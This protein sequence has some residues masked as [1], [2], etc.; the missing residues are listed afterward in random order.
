MPE[1]IKWNWRFGQISDEE[2]FFNLRLFTLKF[3][4]ENNI[5]SLQGW[6]ALVEISYLVKSQ[7]LSSLHCTAICAIS[8]N[9]SWY[10][11]LKKE[12]DNQVGIVLV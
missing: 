3:K 1:R 4:K 5:D 9:S 11:F 7:K 10:G 12:Q 8:S 6:V 2:L